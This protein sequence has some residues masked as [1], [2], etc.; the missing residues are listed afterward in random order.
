MAYW[1]PFVNLSIHYYG[2]FIR[3]VSGLGTFH[4]T[5]NR[6]LHF[7]CVPIEPISTVT[8]GNLRHKPTTTLRYVLDRSHNQIHSPFVT[9]PGVTV[10]QVI[11]EAFLLRNTHLTQISLF[12]LSSPNH[13]T[14]GCSWL[15]TSNLYQPL[16]TITDVTDF[17]A[18]YTVCD[19]VFDRP[20]V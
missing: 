6:P 5:L 9:P 16:F 7:H 1:L 2:P 12:G 19:A 14:A 13:Q 10:F 20:Y 11:V 18:R 15:C 4:V 17:T 8:S 3:K